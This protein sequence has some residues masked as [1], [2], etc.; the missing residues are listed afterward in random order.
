MRF[1]RNLAN[2]MKKTIT[3]ALGG[4]SFTIEEDAYK[5]LD[6]YLSG[7]RKRFSKDASLEELMEDIESS[8]AE[9]FTEQ[10]GKQKSVV[11]QED[12]HGVISV[13]GDV[14]EIAYED[15]TGEEAKKEES[16]KEEKSTDAP[17][18]LYRNP[19]DVVIGGVCS[20]I[21]AYFGTDPAFIRILFVVFAFLNGIGIVAYIILWISIPEA[22]T[23][24][25][26]LEMRGKPV[27]LSELQELVKEK[28]EF[29]GKEGRTAWERMNKSGM[30][31]AVKKT[32]SV[33]G[34]IIYGLF[35]AI[36]GTI[37]VVLCV[38]AGLTIA[39][40]TA[41]S[42]IL[43]VSP[44]SPGII[45][46]LPIGELAGNP[47]Y[48]AA[49]ISAYFAVLV[50]LV[51][52]SWLG[53]TFINR[54]LTFKAGPSMVLAIIWGVALTVGFH[55][56]AVLAPWAQEKIQ[57]TRNAQTETRAVAV[58]DFQRIT[59]DDALDLRIHAGKTFQVSLNGRAQDLDR[60][61]TSVED[62]M[63]HLSQDDGLR[64]F[65]IC[66]FC[67][68]RRVTG[69]ITVPTL[70]LFEGRDATHAQIEGFTSDMTLLAH[71]AA[72]IEAI[73]DGQ[74]SVTASVRD[75]AR[76][77]LTGSV[78][79]LSAEAHDAS[80]ITAEGLQADHVTVE[81]RDAAR[82]TVWPVFSLEA[83]ASDVSRVRYVGDTATTT[84]QESDIG[85]V[86]QGE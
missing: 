16:T 49:V 8:I 7:L 83:Y 63:L 60:V 23:S 6:A 19:D 56:C 68:T 37:G 12:V 20:G 35:A 69:D 85:K 51:F 54:K 26:K 30:P 27:N 59:A 14:E 64:P 3:I 9:K 76:A 31:G 40:L 45:S 52:L 55:A 79:T 67:F 80:R 47:L 5:T 22:T 13:M 74:K 42:A 36:S 86:E 57:E 75:A 4:R 70:E 17:K 73:L 77:T 10:L 18:R 65:G 34:Q 32:G 2:S 53:S 24:A 15:A 62:G 11:T 58:A 33:I 48:Y 44:G 28:A 61:R 84:I 50:P 46:D 43:L 39:A 81:A 78:K 29:I 25:Q 41:T 1:S 82:V 21:A 66:V 72:R 71:D 38:S